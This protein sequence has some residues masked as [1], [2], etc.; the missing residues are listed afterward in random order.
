MSDDTPT[1]PQQQ[2]SGGSSSPRPWQD[3]PFA[4]QQPVDPTQDRQTPRASS[5][6]TQPVVGNTGYNRARGSVLAFVAILGM[7]VF[8]VIV[9]TSAKQAERSE[10]REYQ[11]CQ[12]A[13]REAGLKERY[14]DIMPNDSDSLDQYGL[15][16]K[17]KSLLPDPDTE[18]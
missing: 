12:Q 13:K 14:D 8:A 2:R 15:D 18:C 3:L 9:G 7:I 11:K 1:G 5:P 17:P 6:G 4:G 10:Q 16:P